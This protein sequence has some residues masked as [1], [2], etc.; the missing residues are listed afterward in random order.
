VRQG[1]G[2]LAKGVDMVKD[3]VGEATKWTGTES[4]AGKPSDQSP[5]F[6]SGP[7]SPGEHW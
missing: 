6:I 5:S 2:V 1:C 3:R 4:T 7:R